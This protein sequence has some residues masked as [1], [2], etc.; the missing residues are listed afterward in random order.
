MAMMQAI[1]G[2]MNLTI[3][4]TYYGKDANGTPYGMVPDL[5]RNRIDIGGELQHSI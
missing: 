1:N 2:R 3:H 4:N 5:M